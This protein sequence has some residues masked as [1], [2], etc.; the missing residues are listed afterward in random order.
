LRR[1]ALAFQVMGS[2][3]LSFTSKVRGV[4]LARSIAPGLFFVAVAV[5]ILSYSGAF[6]T[7]DERAMF[8]SMDSFVK[9]GEFTTN[10][11]YWDYTNV[12]MLTTSGEMVPN[13]EPAQ[14]ILAIPLYLWGRLQ[15]AAMQGAMF[16]NVLVTGGAVA[17]VYLCLL[18][19]GFARRTSALSALIFAFGTIAW[20]YSKSFFRDPLAMTMYLLALYGLLRYRPPAPRGWLWPAVT[21]LAVGIALTTKQVSVALIPSLLILVVAYEWQR[22]GTAGERAR[23]GMAALLPLAVVLLLGQLYYLRTL[24]GVELF[25]RNIVDF[26]TNPQLS[27]TDPL[28]MV[29]AGLGLTISPFRGVFWYAPVLL[30]ALVGAIPFLRRRPWEGIAFLLLFAA[31]LIGYSRYLYW[32]AG[33]GGAAWGSRYMLVTVPFLVMLAAPVIE[34]LLRDGAWRSR[35]SPLALVGMAAAWLLVGLSVFIQ[36]IGVSIDT[37]T[38]ELRYILAQAEVWGGVGEAIDATYMNP[39]F[40]P[41]FGNLRL[42]LAGTEPLDV[43]WVRLGA[44]GG[45][46]LLPPALFL[47]LL[48]LG[49]A[50]TGLALMWRRAPIAGV[51]TAVL[52][53]TTLVIATILLSI[54]RQPDSRFDPHNVDRFLQPVLAMLEEAPCEPRGAGIGYRCDA[55][56]VVPDPVLTNYF[57]TRLDAPLPWYAID[58]V[59]A[60][61]DI[62]LLDQLISRY[63]TIYLVRDRSAQADDEQGRREVERYLSEQAY[64]VSEERVEEWAR[65]VR[66]SGAGSLVEWN[67]QPRPLGELT[68]MRSVLRVQREQA[69]APR[70]GAADSTGAQ[71]TDDRQVY[72]NGGDTLQIGLQWRAEET[73]QAN[74]TVFVQ[75]LNSEPGVVAQLDRPP[76]DGL[77]S[78]AALEPGETIQDNLALPLD[79]PPGA[80]QLITG[81]YR[82]DVEGYPRLVGPE[83][84][85]LVL[86]E[87]VVLE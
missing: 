81:L 18:E 80:Y 27:S 66:F 19:L 1:R 64:K 60:P 75:V 70:E 28:R 67:N 21:G 45:W 20:A 72:L 4:A 33:A 87:V 54:Y 51:V 23:A 42:M 40:S 65:L 30:L 52:A 85:Y 61:E 10:Q 7:N 41:V 55:V 78:T 24:S 29:R 46:S 83:G 53:F 36:I 44:Q 3:W 26:T 9:R 58:S 69:I 8:S 59:P 86:A 71:A 38:Y 82:P 37:T 43:A 32:S 68:L 62:Q 22:P 47:S 34:W 12:G 48:N 76:G 5:Y 49:M 56:M 2:S 25:A 77:Y 39:V 73:P 16:F 31:H 35:R 14:S 13:Y 50:V 74:Y 11:I 79:L 63:P 15:G 57:L 84:D 17:L 6:K